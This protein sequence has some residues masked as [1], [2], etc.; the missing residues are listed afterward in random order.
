MSNSFLVHVSEC[1]NIPDRD[2]LLKEG[3]NYYTFLENEELQ[4]LLLDWLAQNKMKHFNDGGHFHITCE[5]RDSAYRVGRK[6]SGILRNS[7]YVSAGLEEG[8]KD[9]IK[10]TIDGDEVKSRNPFAS[11]AKQRGGAGAH[12]DQNDK[13][14]QKLNPRKARRGSKF[15]KRDVEEDI[16][17][18]DWEEDMLNVG[19]DDADDEDLSFSFSGKTDLKE[20]KGNNM[21]RNTLNES[22]LGG[23]MGM[24]KVQPMS[25]DS[26]RLKQL[27]GIKSKVSEYKDSV[28]TVGDATDELGDDMV[29]GKSRP[30]PRP[31]PE[32]VDATGMNL[33]SQDSDYDHKDMD[34]SPELAPNDI[35]GQP[36]ATPETSEAYNYIMHEVGEIQAL[37]DD[38]KLG[39]YKIVVGQ[40][41]ALIQQVKTQ[42]SQAIAETKRKYMAR[43]I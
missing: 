41:E 34:M 31:T 42:G 18:K 27:A 1:E 21:K 3:F 16:N 24:Q 8:K 4:E 13:R 2:L 29:P 12:V 17:P 14:N 26:S 19:V 30:T 25:F 11:V 43:K 9:K 23:V 22:V 10:F 32:P 28:A 39:E 7:R 20:S 15:S 35:G 33:R 6:I 5:D 37:V 38:L 36:E 40:L